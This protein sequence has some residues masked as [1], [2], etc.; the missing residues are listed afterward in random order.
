MLQTKANSTFEAQQNVAK[1][2]LI[3][4]NQILSSSI[5]ESIKCV[6]PAVVLEYNRNDNMVRVQPAAN[7]KNPDGTY[8][9]RYPLWI[10]VWNYGGGGFVINFPLKQGDNGFIV[11]DDYDTSA[12]WDSKSIYNPTTIGMHKYE[13]GFFLP[14]VRPSSEVSISSSD[15]QKLVIQTLDGS[16]K[17]TLSPDGE[18]EIV[19]PSKTTITTPLAEFS[20]DIKVNGQATIVGDA[21]IGNISFN[22]HVHGGVE[23]GGSNTSTPL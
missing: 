2:N 1:P 14:D 20:G 10:P 13:Y 4:L 7:I 22:N 3:T 23:S 6:I 17:I 21:N 18:A 8:T 5:I 12:Y 9:E 19:A 15:A 16:A 11:A